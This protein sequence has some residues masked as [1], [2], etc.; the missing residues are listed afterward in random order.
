MKANKKGISN[1]LL[2]FI[3]SMEHY[4]KGDFIYNQ[5]DSINKI[6]IIK[7][8]FVK[9]GRKV[10]RNKYYNIGLYKEDETLGVIGL[11]DED[12]KYQS[13][14][15]VISKSA[16][17][18]VVRR[19][20]IKDKLFNN[21]EFYKQCISFSS[22]WFCDHILKLYDIAVLKKREALYTTIT[23]LANS[24]GVETEEGILI[25]IQITNDQLA[26]F[27]GISS[28]ESINRMLKE[29]R[30][31]KIISIN[32]KKITVHKSLINKNECYFI[33]I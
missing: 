20:D 16:D 23:R 4:E 5:N 18:Y 15:Q 2:P 30:D 25:D 3:K 26:D 33:N 21:I 29:L 8:G 12:P 32:K 7:S 11:F 13:D 22:N 31:S 28:K 17:V 6:Y 27:S 14:A 1:F 24:Y 9:L 10:A 19:E